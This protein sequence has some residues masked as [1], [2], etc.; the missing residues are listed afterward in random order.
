MKSKN[1]YTVN[2]GNI[3]NMEYT[4]KRLA[5]DCFKTYVSLSKQGKTRAAG[6]DIILMCNDVIIDEYIGTL[7]EGCS[8]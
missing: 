3:G 4:D 1:N 7:N 2:V 8:E 5:I 6:E